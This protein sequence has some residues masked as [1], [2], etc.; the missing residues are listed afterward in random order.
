MYTYMCLYNVHI[1]WTGFMIKGLLLHWNWF[2]CVLHTCVAECAGIKM[3]GLYIY[4]WMNEWMNE[5]M[6]NFNRHSSH[7]HH[8]SMRRKLAQNAHSHGS[9]AFTHALASTRLQPRGAKCQLSYYF[10]V[11]AGSF[12]VSVIHQTLTW[13]TGSLSCAHGHSCACMHVH[14]GVG[15]TNN[16]SAQHFLLGK[17]HNVLLC[18]WRDLNVSPLDLESNTLLIEP[19]RHS[20]EEHSFVLRMCPWWF[21]STLYYFAWQVRVIIGDSD[22]WGCVSCYICVTPLERC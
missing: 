7:V 17:T 21:L 5:W 11:H 12:C 2:Y 10:S 9:H 3:D 13:N 18:S 16:E 6:K 15:L 20:I 14:T 4:E 8:G 22:L 19:S 1:C